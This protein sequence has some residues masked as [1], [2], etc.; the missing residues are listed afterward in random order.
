MCNCCSSRSFVS[1]DE[2]IEILKEYK[3]S[4]EKEAKGVEEEI[5]RVKKAA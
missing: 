5:Q 2:K 3:D 1:K 4:L